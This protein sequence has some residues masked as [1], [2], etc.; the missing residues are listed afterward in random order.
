MYALLLF[1]HPLT[2]ILDIFCNSWLVCSFPSLSEFIWPSSPFV[3]DGCRASGILLWLFKNFILFYFCKLPAR[4]QVYFLCLYIRAIP[5][6]WE[7]L[8]REKKNLWMNLMFTSSFVC[9][10][11]APWN[12]CIYDML[13]SFWERLSESSCAGCISVHLFH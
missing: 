10:L 9:V 12:S 2:V 4:L 11:I 6:W 5:K 8:R 3:S 13:K 7:M 1:F